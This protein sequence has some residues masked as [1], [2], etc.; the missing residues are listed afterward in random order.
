MFLSVYTLIKCSFLTLRLAYLV[1]NR[2]MRRVFGRSQRFALLLSLAQLFCSE[3][4]ARTK[5]QTRH[6]SSSL[7]CGMFTL[8]FIMVFFVLFCFF[9]PCV[10]GH[11]HHCLV[12]VWQQILPLIPFFNTVHL[13]LFSCFWDKGQ[14]CVCVCVCLC[15]FACRS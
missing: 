11:F 6:F 14:W 3:G 4:W 9:P 12:F 13:L 1:A 8:P 15:V 10:D 7:L 5:S 2:M